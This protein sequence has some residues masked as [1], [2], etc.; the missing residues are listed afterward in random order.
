MM[1][2]LLASRSSMVV[3]LAGSALAARTVLHAEP[4]H[5]VCS[6][7]LLP[8][9]DGISLLREVGERWPLVHRVLM[10]GHAEPDW[11]ADLPYLVLH[12]GMAS[13]TAVRDLLVLMAR[14]G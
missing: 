4:V 10:S 8:D 5:L 12:K 11:V 2:R 7:Y 14:A 1:G 13:P 9:T 3:R 6:D